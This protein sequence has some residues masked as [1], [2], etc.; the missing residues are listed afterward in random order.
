MTINPSTGTITATK[1]A[2]AHNGTVGATT[3]STGA[4]TTLSA[5][6][7]VSGTGFTNRFAS[8]GPIGSTTASTGAFT[9]L[10]SSGTVSGTGF[11]VYMLS[12]PE[13]GTTTPNI[14]TFT[15]LTVSGANELRLA[16]SD[17]TNYVGFK[18]PATVSANKIWTL[19][20]AD[21]TSGQVLSTNG[22]GTLSWA[23]GGGSGTVTSVGGT[24][25]VNGLTL[26]GTVTT[27]GSLTLGGTLNL[28]SPPAIGSTTAS[29]GAFTTLSAS[30]TVSGAGF[31]A[32]LASPPSIGSTTASTG[33]FTSL[34][35]KNPIEPIYAIAN[36]SGATTL[37]P[38]CANGSVQSFNMS[39]ATSLT[40][41]SFTNATAGQSLT[42]IVT[43]NTISTITSTMKWAGGV[44][45]L[46][47][48][49]SAI[50]IISVYYDGT[51]YYASI[52]K[53]F[54]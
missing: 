46:T 37:A 1:F 18:S 26:T 48:T 20:A 32:Y 45:T 50:D 19:P 6:S 44:K 31:S 7:T 23:N 4:F 42:I 8:P 13:I 9:S 52:S 2:G 27:S 14:G 11:T 21:G 40:F 15:T 51:N 35:F 47:G 34:E 22:T 36:G 10:S 38:D 28:S 3:P 24:G 12:P 39:T 41:N 5:S 29:T 30:S 33:K 49:A 25:T 16:D 53:G 43:N 17:S 54:A